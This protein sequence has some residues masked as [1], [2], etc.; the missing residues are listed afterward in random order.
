MVVIIF[1]AAALAALIWTGL[2][3]VPPREKLDSGKGCGEKPLY[4]VKIWE[5]IATPAHRA[6]RSDPRYRRE[7]FER[8]APLL[9]S[10]LER[11]IPRRRGWKCWFWYACFRVHYAVLMTRRL[12]LLLPWNRDD[13]NLLLVLILRAAEACTRG[14]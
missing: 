14:S 9:R 10:D 4:A 6:S 8:Y 5:E 2:L 3:L 7:L 12:R 1:A 13:L 11:L